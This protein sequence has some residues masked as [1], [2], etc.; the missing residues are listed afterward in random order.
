MTALPSKR[1]IEEFCEAA[2][3][4]GQDAAERR[5]LLHLRAENALLTAQVKRL[6][7]ERTE[8]RNARRDDQQYIESLQMQLAVYQAA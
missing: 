2:D 6:R 3:Q 7:D 4:R 5:E 1:Q 8:L